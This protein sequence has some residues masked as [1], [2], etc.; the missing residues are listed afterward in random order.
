VTG[1]AGRVALVT[2]ANHG[3][4]AATAER[5]A[6]D[7]AAVLVTF[8]RAPVAEDPGTPQR[9]HEN[10]MIDGE[11]VVL[12]I[13]AAG[14]RAVS[15]E[16][17]LRNPASIAFLFDTAEQQLGPVD[18][19]VNNATGWSSGDSFWA[20]T[21]DPAGRTALAVTAELFDT[22]F[23]VDARAAALLIGELSYRHVQRGASWGRIVGLTSGDQRDGFPSEVT[24]GAAKAAQVSFTMS[25]ATEL[26]RLGITANVVYPPITDSGWVN[27]KVR[28]FATTSD[29]HFHVAEPS[30]VAGVIAW[31]CSD[32]AR[33][34]TGNILR[35][36]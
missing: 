28:A 15:V 11:D 14:G 30:E 23:G 1:L 16:C 17:D 22:T 3:I 19:L 2:G 32:A 33:M 10:R 21:R 12:R 6:A 9:Y 29:E 31:L 35:M 24:Y 13:I 27:D 36:R 5:L 18:I 25:A 34:V 20:G 4:G 26:G 8:L 7:G